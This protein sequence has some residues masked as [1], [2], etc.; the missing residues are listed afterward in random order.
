MERLKIHPM[1]ATRTELFICGASLKWRLT[2]HSWSY[3]VTHVMDLT[4][5]MPET[6]LLSQDFLD[7]IQASAEAHRSSVNRMNARNL[8]EDE[9]DG[10]DGM[11]LIEQGKGIELYQ[12]RIKHAFYRGLGSE[13]VEVLQSYTNTVQKSYESVVSYFTRHRL[14]HGVDVAN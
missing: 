10:V 4:E 5:T 9:F 13:I 3:K 2:S 7:I 14:M 12:Q 6:I 11:A 1:P 8:L